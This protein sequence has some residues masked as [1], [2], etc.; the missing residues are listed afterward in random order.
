MSITYPDWKPFIS[1]FKVN[2]EKLLKKIETLQVNAKEMERIKND[3]GWVAAME[4]MMVNNNTTIPN[5]GS[6]EGLDSNSM[7]SIP[8]AKPSKSKHQRPPRSITTNN[9]SDPDDDDSSSSN[10]SS[11]SH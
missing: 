1:E 3:C 10:E 6:S 8:G 2:N 11:K 7:C 9:P 4:G 5:K